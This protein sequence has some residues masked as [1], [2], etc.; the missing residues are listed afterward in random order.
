MV[1]NRSIHT[2]RTS[3]QWRIGMR[4]AIVAACLPAVLLAGAA[5]SGATGLPAATPFAYT[6]SVATYQVPSDVCQ[7]TI[8]A[9]GAEGGF[10]YYNLA[11]GVGGT[12]QA[13]FAVTPGEEL[14][15]VVGG[16]GLGSDG[17]TGELAGGYGG[18]GATGSDGDSVAGSGGGATTISAGSSTLLVAGG[19]GGTGFVNGPG[20]EGGS[21]GSATQSGTAGTAAPEEFGGA[22]GGGGGTISAGGTGGVAGASEGPNAGTAGSPGV[23]GQ[24]GQGGAGTIAVGAGGGGGYFGGGGGGTG[25]DADFAG[26]G[27]G[28]GSGYAASAA[29]NVTTWSGQ[30]GTGNGA[31][32]IT[33]LAA[34]LVPVLRF[35]SALHVSRIGRTYTP[36]VRTTGGS[37]PVELAI[38]SG[39]SNICSDDGS[40]V[41]F[42]QLGKCDIVASEAASSGFSAATPVTQVV[43]VRATPPSAPLDPSLRSTQGGL[44][45]SWSAPS[46]DDGSPVIEYFARAFPSHSCHTTALG[47]QIVGLTTGVRYVVRV[48]A[49]NIAGRGPWSKPTTLALG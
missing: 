30:P 40:V 23:A 6:G 13:T 20:G 43:V 15:V 11:G 10:N 41:T 19:G 33:P 42:S 24:G 8:D 37:A 26:G 25:D 48:R 34:C 44:A 9:A 38:A 18:G 49:E 47:C 36:D 45:V 12:A 29:T 28:G 5:T 39:S 32:E 22:G 27:G 14:T 3:R 21:G 16:E 31:A 7:L 17:S 35:A 2:V 4:V 1:I 46:S